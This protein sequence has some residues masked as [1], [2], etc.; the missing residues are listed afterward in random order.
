M[1]EFWNKTF[2]R[3]ME[4]YFKSCVVS[5]EELQGIFNLNGF[6]PLGLS[7]VIQELAEDSGYAQAGD[8][9]KLMKQLD[10]DL[11]LETK[12]QL[13]KNIENNTIGNMS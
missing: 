13:Q 4:K 2:E 9:L 7:K 3:V 1:N 5:T 6:Q 8:K 11:S 12:N 10:M